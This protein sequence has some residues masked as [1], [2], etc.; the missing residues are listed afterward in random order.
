VSGQEQSSLLKP[1]LSKITFTQQG[2]EHMAKKAKRK[3]LSL[4]EQ[5]ERLFVPVPFIAT[6]TLYDLRQPDFRPMINSVVSGGAAEQP[7]ESWSTMN[8]KLGGSTS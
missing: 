3:E 7:V 5:H 6:N 8:A 2:M 1:L 4:M